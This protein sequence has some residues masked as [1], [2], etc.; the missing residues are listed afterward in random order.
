[1]PYAVCRQRVAAV[2]AAGAL[3]LVLAAVA[4]GLAAAKNYGSGLSS[5]A[6]GLGM[7]PYHHLGARALHRG[8][9][10]HD[11]RVAQDYLRRAGFPARVDGVYGRGTA[12]AVLS[13]ERAMG[14]TI[15]GALS[16]PDIKALRG[17]VEHGGAFRARTIRA[18]APTT[19]TAGL[20]PDG[21][22]TA[23]VDAP[24]EVQA[25]I[26]AGNV[27]AHKPY[28]YG[29]G[30]GKWPA[31]DSGYDCSGSVSFALHGA[32]LLTRPLA[33]YDFEHWGAPGPGEWVTIYANGG[34]AYMV[35]AGLRF[36]TSGRSRT[37]SRWQTA[38]RSSA[39]YEVVHPEGL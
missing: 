31:H 14:L 36:D 19:E 2:L 26:A 12:R 21:T 11:V 20:N 24:P 30:H 35:V 15:D 16:K 6:G 38:M 7:D 32:G 34:H 8:L 22:A 9:Q 23:P 5:Q 1:V 27:I 4:P 29:G 17:L 37:G 13:F 39:G 33:S 18:V 10:G 28:R 25:I 3:L